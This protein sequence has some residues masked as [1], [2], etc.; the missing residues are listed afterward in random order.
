VEEGRRPHN[1]LASPPVFAKN[2]ELGFQSIPRMKLAAA[3]SL[4]T[5]ALGRMNALYSRTVFDEWVVVS[6]QPDRGSILAYDG[7]RA[8]E[9]RQR[10]AGDIGPLR[11]EMTG[12][13]FAVG[14]FEFAPAATGTRFDACLRIGEAGYLICS[15]TG[16]SMAEIRKDPRWLQ[17]QTA[18]VEL[19]GKFCADPLE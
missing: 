13:R 4:I 12:K 6:L 11:N 3:R 7:P 8:G 15:H 5:A 1:R 2:H 17:A 10:F 16:K 19:S 18:F 14:D 9:F